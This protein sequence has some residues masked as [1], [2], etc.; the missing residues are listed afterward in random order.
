MC[1]LHS[2]QGLGDRPASVALDEGRHH[3][4]LELLGVVEDV[5]VDAEDLG[6]PARVV[7]VG[8]RAAARV[9][10]PAPELQ[11]RADDLV[12]RFEQQRR[13]DRRVDAATHRYEDFHAS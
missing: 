4:A 8:D 6:H 1:R 12:A 7:D 3:V 11:R 10:D 5:V 2:M 9:R 13:G